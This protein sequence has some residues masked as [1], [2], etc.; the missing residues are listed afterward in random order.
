MFLSEAPLPW[1]L[2]AVFLLEWIPNR[3]SCAQSGDRMDQKVTKGIFKNKHATRQ[4]GRASVDIAPISLWTLLDLGRIAGRPRKTFGQSVS[5]LWCPS[6]IFLPT[7]HFPFKLLQVLVEQECLTRCEK[8]IENFQ[9]QLPELPGTSWWCPTLACTLLRS[10]LAPMGDAQDRRIHDST[11]MVI[12]RLWHLSEEHLLR[13]RW[14][15]PLQFPSPKHCCWL[16]DYSQGFKVFTR[17]SRT[18]H[19]ASEPVIVCFV[20]LA[21]ANEKNPASKVP[22]WRSYSS[23]GVGQELNAWPAMII[24]MF[25]N[26]HDSYGWVALNKKKLIDV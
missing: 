9:L 23:W 4:T 6:N 16:V 17:R 8:K 3:P 20:Y 24:Q 19:I 10:L 13:R 18:Y 2:E 11:S 25:E 5:D 1:T 14:R 12:K 7:E 26:G 21:D 22:T 15:Q